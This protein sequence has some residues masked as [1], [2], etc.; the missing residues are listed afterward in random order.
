[1]SLRDHWSFEPRIGD[2]YAARIDCSK[3]IA[4]EVEQIGSPIKAN[5]YDILPDIL[6]SKKSE[7]TSAL[8]AYKHFLEKCEKRFSKMGVHRPE[9]LG[10]Q[11]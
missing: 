9:F 7:E 11:V 3:E 5:L 1:M 10:F 6:P 4:T 8:T 2:L